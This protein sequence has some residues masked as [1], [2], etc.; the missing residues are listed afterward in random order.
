MFLL[1]V[2]FWEKTGMIQPVTSPAVIT[3]CH[4]SDV[5]YILAISDNDLAKQNASAWIEVWGKG[6]G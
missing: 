6:G 4:S 1:M 5:A 3:I 2:M